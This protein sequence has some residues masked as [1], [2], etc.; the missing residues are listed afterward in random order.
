MSIAD[1]L[2]K[3]VRQAKEN[4]AG[5]APTDS[6]NPEPTPTQARKPATA[7]PSKSSR[8]ATGKKSKPVASVA[9]FPSRRVW[10]D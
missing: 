5:D 7:A 4:P 8:S 3:S 2:A 10:P 1:K 9:P 6:S